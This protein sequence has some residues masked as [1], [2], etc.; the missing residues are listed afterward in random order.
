MA[1]VRSALHRAL[2]AIAPPPLDPEHKVVVH[3]K[4]RRIH[5]NGITRGEETYWAVI[6]DTGPGTGTRLS[7]RRRVLATRT[8]ELDAQK[9]ADRQRRIRGMQEMHNYTE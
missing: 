9:E 8:R 3:Q 6:F 1:K 5:R 7:P 2:E 4:K